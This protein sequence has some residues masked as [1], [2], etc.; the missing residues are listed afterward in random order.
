MLI[1]AFFSACYTNIWGPNIIKSLF[2]NFLVA[3]YYF[4]LGLKH[5]IL[6]GS[7]LNRKVNNS[8]YLQE[9]PEVDHIH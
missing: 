8:K 6:K 3:V 4:A 2:Y 7:S 1:L 5:S 9:V